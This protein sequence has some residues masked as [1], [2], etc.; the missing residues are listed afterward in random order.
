M[1]CHLHLLFIFDVVGMEEFYSLPDEAVAHAK[2]LN[3]NDFISPA[4][5]AG[6]LDIKVWGIIMS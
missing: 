2:F 4:M 6:K 1:A 5:S 3:A